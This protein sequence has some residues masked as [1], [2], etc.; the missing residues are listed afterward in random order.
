M[1]EPDRHEQQSPADQGAQE[2]K[3]FGRYPEPKEVDGEDPR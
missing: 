2:S 1:D 3:A